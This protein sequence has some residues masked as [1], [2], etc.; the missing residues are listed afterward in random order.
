LD[1][2]TSAN[3]RLEAFIN[4]VTRKRSF[5]LICEPPMQ[6]PAKVLLPRRS[7][8]QAGQSLSRVPA[9]KRGEILIMQQLGLVTRLSTPSISM[10]KAYEELYEI[11]TDPT[12]SSIKAL[13][14]LFNNDIG[15]ELH[16]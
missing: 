14:E 12:A 5:P 8:R 11:K 15:N 13:P 2:D 1:N 4:K 16:R 10:I 9:S 3:R 6:P 7:K